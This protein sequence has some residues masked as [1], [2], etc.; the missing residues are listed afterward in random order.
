MIEAYGA[1][2]L[3]STPWRKKFRNADALNRW[4][5]ANDAVVY[6]TREV[7]S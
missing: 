6:G 7:A 5:E 1:K 2:G 4:V 3:K